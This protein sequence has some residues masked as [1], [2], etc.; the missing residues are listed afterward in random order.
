MRTHHESEYLKLPHNSE[1]KWPD[2]KSLFQCPFCSAIAKLPKEEEHEYWM[3]FYPLI[4]VVEANRSEMTLA[5]R[6]ICRLVCLDCMQQNLDGMF[7]TIKQTEKTNSVFS[8]SAMEML[9]EAG[10]VS[11]LQ[12]GPPRPK[13]HPHVDDPIDAWTLYTL[14]ESTGAWQAL[15][16]DYCGALTRSLEAH[17]SPGEDHTEWL[18]TKDRY[19]RS[20]GN[21]ECD[22]VHGKKTS[23]GE[24][25]RL[26]VVCKQCKI[27]YYCSKLCRNTAW[28][29]HSLE[30]QAGTK[31]VKLVQ[32]D[33]C[34]MTMP[35][36]KLKKCA[37]CRSVVYCSVECQRG[38]WPRH[39][40]VCKET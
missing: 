7:L 29:L 23:D 16:N 22:R 9:Q 25:T 11:F 21:Q 38:A 6:T 19:G 4:Q 33:A 3:V 2:V 24:I 8:L 14:W 15:Q 30:C 10:T 39:K 31:K 32:C 13:H 26:S 17:P 20:C 36:T 28:T 5:T 40:A 12:D 1:Y 35:Y 34:L 27:E 18:Q 37:R